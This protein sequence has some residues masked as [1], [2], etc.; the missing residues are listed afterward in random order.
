MSRTSSSDDVNSRGR[1][2][3]DNERVSTDYDFGF[4]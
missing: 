3:D 4:R 1:D 2:E